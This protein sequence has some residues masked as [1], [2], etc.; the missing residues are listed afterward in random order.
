MNTSS[1]R[2]HFDITHARTELTKY[3]DFILSH[4]DYHR[5]KPH[6]EPYLTALKR[7][8]LRPEQCI[9]VE[10]SERGLASAMAAGLECLIVLSEWSKD[11]DFRK[12]RKVLS[13]L[14]EVPSEV[15]RIAGIRGPGS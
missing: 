11:G 7:H 9:V 8:H 6:P 2:Q 10:D 3:L 14:A 12:A 1:R 15:L 5:S 13:N 4:E